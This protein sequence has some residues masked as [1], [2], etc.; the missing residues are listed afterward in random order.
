MKWLASLLLGQLMLSVAFAQ[1]PSRL[2][3]PAFR[4]TLREDPNSTLALGPSCAAEVAQTLTCRGFVLTLENASTQIIYPT[5]NCGENLIWMYKKNSRTVPDGWQ[6]VSRTT[7]SSCEPRP[8]IRSR[9]RPGE[10]TDIAVRLIEP[11][12]TADSFGPGSYTFRAGWNFWA[13]PEK[14]D[15]DDCLA[16]IDGGR[17]VPASAV[18]NEITVESPRQPDLGALNFSFEVAVRAGLPANA[19]SSRATAGCSA[20]TSG[21]INCTVFHYTIRNRSDRPVRNATS[22]HDDISNCV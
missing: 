2:Q 11:G 4:L 21:S 6:P 16:S 13:C 1:S 17:L 20:D 18:S 22:K 14:A 8:M 10:R 12:R 7:Q 19:T 3:L 9:L 5:D 15:S